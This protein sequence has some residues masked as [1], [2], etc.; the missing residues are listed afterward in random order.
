MTRTMTFALA[1]LVLGVPATAQQQ[2]AD[3]HAGHAMEAQAPKPA[4]PAAVNAA[5]PPD[6]NRAAEAVKTSPRHGE[7]VDV[8]VPGSSTPIV[9]W[10]VY[11]ER[12]E[13]AGVVIV[14]HEIFGLTDW[15]R[16]VADQLAKD[17]FIAVAPD[18][19]S[20][21][22]PNGGGSAELGQ[23]NATKVIR[24]LTPEEVTNAL[25]AVREYAIKLPAA[26]GKS[27]VVGFCW[28][29]SSSFAYATNQ[30]ALNAAVVYYGTSPQEAD[31]YERIKAP[32]LG[33]YGGDDARVNA[34]IPTA[35]ENMKKPGKR[36]E[37]HV[38]DGAGHGFLRQQ[39]GKE[40][41]NMKATGQA[42]PLTLAFLRQHLK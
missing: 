24:T 40:G 32:V 10:V 41:A 17:G 1:V 38:F 26:N 6:A 11:P 12:K 8:K 2:Q 27:G 36:Y 4:Q 30:P 3:P 23:D 16:G 9:T 33:L 34:T 5:L 7:F 13:K 37:P 39:D 22:G 14:I 42:W 31:A 15:I 29:G 21:K 20:G 19:L 28:G 35:E 18:L 25:N